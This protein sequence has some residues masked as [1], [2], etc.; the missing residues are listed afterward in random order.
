VDETDR[1]HII[2][3]HSAGIHTSSADV[4]G[5]SPFEKLK[6]RS[7]W[8]EPVSLSGEGCS[9]GDAL[10]LPDG[11]LA[12]Y[13][14]R[15]QALIELI[16]ESGETV[17]SEDG[18]HPNVFV[19]TAG[20]RHIAFER[21]RRVFYS[22]FDGV[23]WLDS[24]GQPGAEMVAYFCSSW[25]SIAVTNLGAIVIAYQGEGKV[26]LRKFPEIYDRMRPGG[27]STVSYAVNKGGG[28][29]IHDLLRSSEILL[30]RRV[31]SSLPSV[32]KSGQFKSHLEEFWRPAL[33][34]DKHGVIWMFFLNTTRR[35]IFFTRFGGESFG[36]YYEARGAYDCPTRNYFVQ[37]EALCLV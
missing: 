37:R 16:V 31:S 23:E 13:M 24:R 20:R 2:Y 35:H 27:G 36:D 6:D 14:T 7:A 32:G 3:V 33:S 15:E 1:L 29:K 26:D 18:E 12:V 8:A 25:P 5:E 22:V 21:D 28:W 4:A 34:I 9:L 19:D 17:I 30:K 10:F 11:N